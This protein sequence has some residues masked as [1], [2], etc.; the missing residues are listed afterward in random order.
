MSVGWTEDATVQMNMTGADCVASA[1]RTY[2]QLIFR[3]NSSAVAPHIQ[4]EAES[5][6]KCYVKISIDTVELCKNSPPPPAQYRC[7]KDSCVPTTSGGVSKEE[8][9]VSCNPAMFACQANTC[10][11]VSKGG[12]PRS[13]C[14]STCKSDRYQCVKNNCIP[15]AEGG[16]SKSDCQK[17]CIEPPLR[18]ICKN[19]QCIKTQTGGTPLS[20]CEKNCLPDVRY[21][22]QATRCVHTQTGGVSKADCLRFCEGVFMDNAT[23]GFHDSK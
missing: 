8:C 16:V 10:V 2:S 6:E 11:S 20:D 9:A 17:T 19:Q 3:C 15:V 13:Q 1:G 14:E 7:E 4:L 12:V 23:S 5:F 22:C 18:Y 21:E